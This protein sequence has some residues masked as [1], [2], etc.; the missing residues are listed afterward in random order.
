MTSADSCRMGGIENV[1]TVEDGPDS[2]LMPMCGSAG[3]RGDLWE[4]N[5]LPW[6][7]FVEKQY[8]GR[9]G[10]DRRPDIVGNGGEVGGDPQTEPL[11]L[12]LVWK[13]PYNGK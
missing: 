6:R 11:I 8:G 12:P 3:G 2:V 5:G 9:R 7:H 1:E 13:S 4:L 10:R